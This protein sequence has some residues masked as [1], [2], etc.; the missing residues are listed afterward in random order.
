M[1]QTTSRRD[2][3]ERMDKMVSTWRFGSLSCSKSI[4]IIEP[5]IREFPR[6]KIC[7]KSSN[8][9]AGNPLEIY[10]RCISVLIH[11]DDCRE[12]M[13]SLCSLFCLHLKNRFGIVRIY[14]YMKI[15]T[16]GVVKEF[17]R[18]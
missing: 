15:K 8:G 16:L 7:R 2:H 4:S 14:T 18:K 6:S 12:G 3:D 9:R 17:I 13:S 1:I 10:P 11:K 5:V